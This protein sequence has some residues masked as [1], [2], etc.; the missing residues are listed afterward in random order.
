MVSIERVRVRGLRSLRDV[1]LAMSPLTVLIGANG[2][3]KSNFA[4]VFQLL[5]FVQSRSL[6]QF[7]TDH[8]GASAL[9][10]RGAKATPELTVELELRDEIG[11]LGYRV[12]LVATAGDQLWIR[13]EAVCGRAPGDDAASARDWIVVTSNARESELTDR[14]KDEPVAKRVNH[15]VRSLKQ[16]H[17]PDTSKNSSLRSRAKQGDDKYLRADGGNLAA[18]LLARRDDDTVPGRAAWRR[19]LHLFQRVAPFVK[20]LSP[21]NVGGGGVELRGSDELDEVGGVDALSDGTLRALALFAMLTQPPSGLPRLLVIDEPELGLHPVAIHLLVS[22][23]RS[24]SGDCQVVLATQSSAVLDLAQ[25]AEVVV[26]ERSEAASIFRRLDV[27]A[28]AGWLREFAPG[29]GD[30]AA[31]S[32]LAEMNLLGGRP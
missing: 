3:G 7:V 1:E 27:D 11:P 2:A 20:E 9:L 5:S 8:N 25:P 16:Q 12:K 29:D 4:K 18:F 26:A 14:A 21:Q 17:V 10:H 13:E 31:L 15:V 22:L 28:V 32:D 6:G 19:F 23:C 24:V 30:E